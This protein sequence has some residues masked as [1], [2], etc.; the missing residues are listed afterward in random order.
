[1]PMIPAIQLQGQNKVVRLM[2]MGHAF[3]QLGGVCRGGFRGGV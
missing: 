3:T 2:H 1:M